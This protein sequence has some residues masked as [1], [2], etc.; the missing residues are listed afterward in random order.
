MA[1]RMGKTRSVAVGLS[2]AAPSPG[3]LG[4]L[5]ATSKRGGEGAVLSTDSG[6]A[7]A[8]MVAS[9]GSVAGGSTAVFSDMARRSVVVCHCIPGQLAGE[10]GATRCRREAG[11][12][13]A[14]GKEEALFLV[15]SWCV[16]SSFA[17]RNSA[18]S[19]LGQRHKGGH[20]PTGMPGVDRPYAGPSSGAVVHAGCALRVCCWEGV[21]WTWEPTAW[22]EFSREPQVKH[23]GHF[24]GGSN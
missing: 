7:W 11:E 8:S 20:S 9:S 6:I 16:W 13:K 18:L 21:G 15:V 3:V 22:V 23:R 4:P 2:W 10:A 12:R 24:D 5:A 19:Q 14:G 17:R 1:E